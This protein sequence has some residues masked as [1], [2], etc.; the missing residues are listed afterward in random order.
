M[1]L[2]ALFQGLAVLPSGAD[3]IEVSAVTLDSRQVH[4]GVVFVAS[5]GVTSSSKDGHAF[6]NAAVQAGASAVVVEVAVPCS[7]PTIISTNA[8]VLAA[9]LAERINGRPSQH[10]KVAGVTGTNGKTTTTFLLAP[11]R[12]PPNSVLRS[13]GPWALVLRSTCRFQ[14]SPHPKRRCSRHASPPCSVRASTSWPW[15][16]HPTLSPP[17]GSTD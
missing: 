10:L 14:A 15:R 3:D 5:R 11:S 17:L 16:C 2:S 12:V 1:R 13:L 4:P 6:V 9:R 7:A 8:R